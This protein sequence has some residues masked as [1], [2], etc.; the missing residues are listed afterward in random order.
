MAKNTRDILLD[1]T[2]D[3]I[4]KY[5]YFQASTSDILK[6]CHIPKGS[7]YHYFSSKHDLTLCVIN[8]RVKPKTVKNYKIVVK[9]SYF[10]SL[11][12]FLEKIDFSKKAFYY[13][14]VMHK[15]IVETAQHD[16]EF[17]SA[18]YAIYEMVNEHF[19]TILDAA[20]QEGEIKKCDTKEKA[21]FILTALL[22]AISL[23]NDAALAALVKELRV[24]KP[25]KKQTRHTKQQTLF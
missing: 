10:E 24:L 3:E 2:F 20:V 21:N 11:I 5:G 4:H 7:M 22:G 12:A 13:G 8:E 1:Y 18:L 9:D 14:C 15:L 6:K 23:K 19:K 25:L 16:K 17:K